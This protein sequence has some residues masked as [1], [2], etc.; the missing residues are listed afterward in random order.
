MSDMFVLWILDF[1]NIY[2]CF[3]T[4]EFNPGFKGFF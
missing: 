4:D 2:F 1:S 3:F